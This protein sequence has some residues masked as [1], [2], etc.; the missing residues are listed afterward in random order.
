MSIKINLKKYFILNENNKAVQVAREE[1]EKWKQENVSKYNRSKSF[2][3]GYKKASLT[4]I[5]TQEP[6][7]EISLFEVSTEWRGYDGEMIDGPFD[8][9]T[10]SSYEEAVESYEL[11]LIMNGGDD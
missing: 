11:Y 1:Y 6:Y 10:F 9:Q 7:D 3:N 2:D 5:G 8:L 4:F